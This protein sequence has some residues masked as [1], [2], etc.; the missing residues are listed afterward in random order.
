MY[1]ED[2]TITPFDPSAGIWFKYGRLNSSF[3]FYG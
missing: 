2:F 3:V 1:G